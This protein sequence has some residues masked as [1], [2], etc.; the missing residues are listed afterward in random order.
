MRHPNGA[1]RE[2]A[3]YMGLKPRKEISAKDE[4]LGVANLETEVKPWGR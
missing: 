4:D 2:A 3:G 1:I